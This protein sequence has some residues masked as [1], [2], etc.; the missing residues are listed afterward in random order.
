MQDQILRALSGE[1][2]VHSNALATVATSC[3]LL[4]DAGDRSQSIVSLVG[5]TGMNTVK[6]SY[7][8]LL[9]VAA[10]LLLIAAAAH[11]SKEGGAADIPVAFLAGLFVAIYL[12]TRRASIVF[13]VGQERTQT[14]FGSL[15][16]AASI[17]RAIRKAQT[18]FVEETKEA[19]K[20]AS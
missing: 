8:G 18:N 16:E 15:S 20:L 12:G 13:E 9:V 7:P 4:R 14:L 11:Y 19:A 17:V 6:T 1:Q 3:V 5:I 2:I 10:G